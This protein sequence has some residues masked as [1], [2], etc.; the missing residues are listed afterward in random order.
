M[1]RHTSHRRNG[2]ENIWS[3]HCSVC[4]CVD[5]VRPPDSIE[6][7]RSATKTYSATTLVGNHNIMLSMVSRW[8]ESPKAQYKAKMRDKF[9]SCTAS[10]VFWAMRIYI[11]RGERM[12]VV[13]GRLIVCVAVACETIPTTHISIKFTSLSK[14]WKRNS[15]LC[16]AQFAV[17]IL[18]YRFVDITPSI[19]AHT[20]RATPRYVLWACVRCSYIYNEMIKMWVA[21][22]NRI[23]VSL[24]S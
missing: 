6:K 16:S 21:F 3:V 18:A 19:R 10:N 23:S 5:I 2:F 4:A 17:A 13:G 14:Y 1:H 12:L 8:I 9:A 11:Q 20:H 24:T 15:C 7:C 22:Q